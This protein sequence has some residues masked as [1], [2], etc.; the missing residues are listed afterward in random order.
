MCCPTV[1]DDMLLQALTKLALQLLIIFL[2]IRLEYNVLKCNV[3]V[4]N[5]TDAEHKRSNRRWRLGSE[6]LF[7]TDKYTHVG[8]VCTKGM[9]MKYIE[10]LT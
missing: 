1:A 8:I 6:E 5:E 4:C 9:D 3:L 10:G 2:S 7:E